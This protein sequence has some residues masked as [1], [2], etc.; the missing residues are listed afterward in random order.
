MADLKGVREGFQGLAGILLLLLLKSEPPINEAKACR[1]TSQQRTTTKAYS[2]L[3]SPA[4][5]S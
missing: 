4:M 2:R 1:I 3:S 5:L